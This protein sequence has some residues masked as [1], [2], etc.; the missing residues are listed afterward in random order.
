[1]RL[2]IDASNLGLGGGTTHLKELLRHIDAK[3]PQ[4]SA[5]V[6][7]SSQ[8]VLDQVPSNPVVQKVSFPQLN[9]GLLTRVL[10]Q[11]TGYDKQI[12]RYNCDLIFSITGDYLGRLRPVVGMSQ[13][14]LLY[15]RHLWKDFGQL[16][17]TMRM[18]LNFHKQRYSFSNSEGII[19][20]SQHAQSVV[21]KLF[22]LSDKK[23]ALIP[24]G[25]SE[26]FRSAVKPQLPV[27]SYSPSNPFR[28]LYVSTIHSYK[29]QWKVVEA[30]ARLREKGYPLELHLAGSVIF[31][32]A[33][34]LLDESIRRFDPDRQY[35]KEHGWVDFETIHQLYG[36]ADA[37]V[38][39]SECENMPNILIEAMSAG[40]PIVCS[41]RNPMPEFAGEHACYFNPR[42][43]DSM[44]RAIEKMLL[45]PEKRAWKAA[46]NRQASDKYDWN[47]TAEATFR[48]LND[49]YEDFLSK[50]TNTL[51]TS[52]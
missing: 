6:V 51:K 10:F 13:N 11:L 5:V 30:V 52:K 41:D 27:S 35:V 23:L 32:P 1:M 19:F 3:V 29:N 38:F 31:K 47:T 50:Q 39:A 37:F 34:V 43:V 8:A 7:F 14:M 44:V 40:L 4:I 2:A 45:R 42:N 21:G 12:A 18:F 28:L 17:E 15:D 16:R 48:F 49:T 9:K 46:L 26:R 24:H 33:G 25:I 20:I 36:S 22:P